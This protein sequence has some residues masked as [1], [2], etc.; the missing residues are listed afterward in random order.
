MATVL[1]SIKPKFVE[2]IFSGEKR[3]EFRRKIFHKD[4]KQVKIYASAPISKIVGEFEI[5]HILSDTPDKVWEVTKDYAGISK[6]YF[7]EYFKDRDIAYAIRVKNIKIYE[8][9]QSIE[10]SPPQNYRYI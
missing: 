4:C 2:K 3:W 6:E 5:D 10:Y 9:Q 1:L 8:T 7:D